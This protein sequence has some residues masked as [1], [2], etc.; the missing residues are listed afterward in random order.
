[1]ALTTDNAVPVTDVAAVRGSDRVAAGDREAPHPR[2]HLSDA[3][4]DPQTS[5]S[6]ARTRVSTWVVPIAVGLLVRIIYW[7]AITPEWTPR[8]D[9]RQYV[10]LARALA[11]GQ[12]FAARYPG[13][14]LHP[15][16][17]RPPLYPAILAVP[18][19]VFGPDVLWPGRVLAIGI[20][21]GVIALT[22]TYARRIAGDRAGL[23]AGLAVALMPS[24]IANDTITTTESLGLLLM[25]AVLLALLDKRPVVA[26]S[27]VGLMLLTRPNAYLVLL[28]VVIAVWRS[29]GWR[30][31]ASAGGVCLLV[32]SPWVLRNAVV[33][34]TP[35]I[36]TSDGFTLAA[37]YGPPSVRTG[38]FVDPTVD[39]WYRDAGIHGLADDEAEWSDALTNVAVDGIRAHPVEVLQ[40]ATDGAA[41]FLELPGH[42]AWA[43]EIVDGRDTR[44]RD[45]TLFLFPL[46]VVA[47]VAGT[48][49]K[50]KDRRTWPGLAIIG[51]FV[52]LSLV[53]VSVPRL[54]GPFDLL[55]CIGIGYLAAWLDSA[56]KLP[57]DATGVT[58]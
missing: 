39:D 31:A 2:E 19:K 24:L 56:R 58:A 32:V 4:D 50:A 1:M 49:L 51:G 26:G 42:R 10:D 45:A 18:T 21:L 55:M 16:A 15:T 23:V 33:V 47:G 27:M 13:S 52:A 38:G 28:V 44:F 48:A 37:V 57:A 5:Q 14:T 53:T 29:A 22:V 35:K 20:G 34:G 7:V 30:R 25:L 9:A 8:S 3:P 40:R 41:T 36:V 12:G 6:S 54:R 11:A 43:A 46:F 17:F